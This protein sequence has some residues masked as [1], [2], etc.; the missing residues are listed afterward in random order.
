ME[1]D[2]EEI[3]VN[4]WKPKTFD[5]NKTLIARESSFDDLL[6][7]NNAVLK[8]TDWQI[9]IVDLSAAP[10]IRLNFKSTGGLKALDKLI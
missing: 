5:W 9:E 1:F 4:L 7:A 2:V 3:R 10:R 6:M 8:K